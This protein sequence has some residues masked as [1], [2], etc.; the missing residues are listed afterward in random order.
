VLAD[1]TPEEVTELVKSSGLRGRGGA[2]FPT[3]TKW[4]FIPKDVFPRYVVINNDEGEPCTFKDRELT[5]RDPH[6]VIEGALIAAYAVQA[7]AVYIYVRGEFALAHRRLDQA[8]ADARGHGLIGSDILGSGFSCEVFT[9]PGAGAYICGEETALLESLE[10]LRGQPRLRPPFFPAIKGLYN[11]P[12]VVNNSETVASLPKIINKGVDWWRGMGTEKSPGTRIFSLSTG[13]ERPGNYEL[14]LG[15]QLTDL[16]ELG[17]GISGGRRF[18][19]VIFGASAP[20]LVDPS[21]SLDFEAPAEAGSMLGS[22]SVIVLDESSCAVETALITARFFNHE[23]CGK[24]TPC[25]EG[26]WW[27]SKILERVERG[28]GRDDDLEVLVDVSDNMSAPELPYAPKGQC[29]CP[30]GDGAAWSVRSAV[31]LF[32]D[33]FVQHIEDGACPFKQW[34]S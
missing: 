12:T 7:V 30:L 5:E 4:E 17:G 33:E 28:E 6:A 27:Q 18:K 13:I 1:N 9:H 10:G 24:C 29:F 23:S 2:G 19:A 20:W 32:K 11:Q 15:V 3:G 21:I 31:Q 16:L 34:A 14:S 8:I 25:R 22:G 26:T